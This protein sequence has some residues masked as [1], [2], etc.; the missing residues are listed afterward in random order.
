M[1]LY[2]L[3]ELY[4]ATFWV[5]YWWYDIKVSDAETVFSG[6]IPGLLLL[7]ELVPCCALNYL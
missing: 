6:L 3:E 4:I 5:Q 2:S 7:E 1:S